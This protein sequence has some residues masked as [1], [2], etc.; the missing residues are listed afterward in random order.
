MAQNI[1]RFSEDM[2]L[3]IVESKISDR[4]RQS[5]NIIFI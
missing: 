2:Q 5:V 3:F 4:S 1:Q